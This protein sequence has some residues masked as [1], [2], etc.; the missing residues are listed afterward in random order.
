[1]TELSGLHALSENPRFLLARVDGQVGL[2]MS[3]GVVHYR[4]YRRLAVHATAGLNGDRKSTT[5]VV[6][7]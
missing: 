3:L 6:H 4:A 2:K 5:V 1:M 7:L